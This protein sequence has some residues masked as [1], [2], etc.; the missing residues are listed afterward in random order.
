[1]AFAGFPTEGTSW[2]DGLALAQSREWYQAHKQGYELLWLQPMSALLDELKGPLQKVYGK[3]IGK[4]KI[5]RL[6]RDVRFSKDKRPYKTNVAAM[7]P[8]EGFG[9]MEGPAALYLSLGSEEYYGFG[10]W[11]LEAPALQRLRKAILDDKKGAALE[12]LMVAVKRAGMEHSAME[13]LKRP[14]PGVAKDH[15]RVELLKPK[16]LGLG[17]DQIPKA[18]RFSPKLRDF[19]LAQAKVAAPVLKWGWAQKL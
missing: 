5:F 2:L 4:P 14:P 17:S 13:T 3:Q 11:F 6:N 1:M 7:L 15:P 12:K 16:G 19:L 8:F 10:F 9:P 18:V